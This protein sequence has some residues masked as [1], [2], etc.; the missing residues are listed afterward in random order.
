MDVVLSHEIHGSL[1]WPQEKTSAATPVKSNVIQFQLVV[2][3]EDRGIKAQAQECL[4]FAIAKYNLNIPNYFL[5]N[6]YLLHADRQCIE[7][8]VN[9]YSYASHMV[10]ALLI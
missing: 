7:I 10:K 1:L 2:A 6:I 3:Y 5:L 4:N 9:D 8:Y